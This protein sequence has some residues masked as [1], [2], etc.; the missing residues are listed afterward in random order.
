MIY[1]VLRS[2]RRH[3]FAPLLLLLTLPELASGAD[4]FDVQFGALDQPRI[5]AVIRRTPNGNPLVADFGT[6]D[7]TI[8]LQ[9][10]FDTGASGVLISDQSAAYLG[11]NKSRFPEPGGPLVS[12]FDV[13]VG[14]AEEF[15][16]SEPLYIS[17]APFD[18]NSSL[19]LE[20]PANYPH[21]FGPIR[22]QLALPPQ[23]P[24]LAG[25]DVFG[26]PVFAGKVVVMDP[27]PT[28]FYD[29]NGGINPLL[30]SIR[31]FVY[32]PGTPFNPG[33]VDSNPGIP[34][35]NH[36]VKLSYGN[37]ERFTF[38]TPAGAPPATVAH[39]P[40]IGPNPVLQLLAN[41]PADGTPPI[42]ISV[43]E[44]S[45]TCSFLLDTG[46][47]AS[48]I[49]KAKAS[50]F[51][52]RYKAN[53]E[54]TAN[55]QLEYY[56]P[57]NPAAAGTPVPGQ[58]KLT[59]S[60][61][62]GDKTAAG[63][64]LDTLVIPTEQGIAADPGDPNHMR[65]FGAPVLVN[66]IA[67]EDQVTQ[68]TL[69]LDGI[70]GMNFL[71]GSVELIP[72]Q[73][74]PFGALANG[75]YRW[76]TFDEPNGKL[77]LQL[78]ESI[79]VNQWGLTG[80]GDWGTAANWTDG[81]VPDS[82]FDEAYLGKN[83]TTSGNID[84]GATSRTVAALRF[85]NTTSGYTVSSSG[86]KLIF[87]AAFG[88]VYLTNLLSNTQNHTIA[89]PVEFRS[90]TRVF[91]G[92]QQISLTDSVEFTA[93]VGLQIESGTLRFALSVGKSSTLA[94]GMT[95]TIA[96]GSSLELGGAVSALGSAAGN[97]ANIITSAA[98]STLNVTGKNQVV[99]RVSGPTS[100]MALFGSATGQTTIAA[101]SD[102]TAGGLRQNQLSLAAGTALEPTSLN[103]AY[104]GGSA[105]LIV[106]NNT[107]SNGGTGTPGLAL[108]NNSVLDI[109]DNDAVVYFTDNA[110]DPNP[111][112]AIRGYID[113]FYQG[114]T[115]APQIASQ[116]IIDT[117]GATVFVA[118][119]NSNT[120]FGD[121]QGGP[122]YDLTLG[123]S[124]VAGGFQQTIIRYTWGGDYD[125]NGVVDALDYAVVDANLN[126]TVSAG[127]VAGWR[128]GDGDFDGM[129][130]PLDYAAI[131]ANLGKGGPLA[132]PG[133]IAI[134]EPIGGV[135][136]LLLC[137]GFAGLCWK[138][139]LIRHVSKSIKQS[140]PAA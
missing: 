128:F 76:L 130:T 114:V 12:F 9:A 10:F 138:T 87:N 5:N 119:D 118:I 6:G 78:K 139:I 70:L 110:A 92:N 81:F 61:I 73:F 95:A 36:T 85:D 109:F 54:N 3:L 102:L 13:G 2:Q 74:P 24:L 69:T 17:L 8:N 38:T 117:G 123:D 55:P 21:Q 127:G 35:V 56:D 72:D 100:P 58:F 111:T 51:H 28:D 41:P 11:I 84:L 67:L 135:L 134:P 121:A 106:L 48:M 129:V 49:S 122:F 30:G 23:N 77:G 34:A 91:A 108:S 80:G 22:A 43:G 32:N 90:N 37:F 96:G 47:A 26:M 125:L 60:G 25:T 94:A 82:D 89:A 112:A 64:Y 1:A 132:G 115:G 53:T 19:T 99:G 71:V 124:A 88:P 15:H 4:I 131:D 97:K 133:N 52:I 83:L 39:N 57:A 44:L 66:D 116:A 65:Y 14:G 79:T 50:A 140:Q 63:F 113:N 16:V 59:V 27:T 137:G 93:G 105:G 62:G 104:Q 31:T 107:A 86:G 33:T 29:A 75:A 101:G 103:I 40:F 120:G 46:A 7:T 68:Q 126:T 20:N 98:T 136:G 18:E 42:T 45:T